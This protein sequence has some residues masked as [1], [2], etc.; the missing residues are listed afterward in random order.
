MGEFLQEG[1]GFPWFVSK[2]ADGVQTTLKI[3]FPEDRPGTVVIVD[4]TMF[5][6]NET[7]VELGAEEYSHHPKVSDPPTVGRAARAA[8]GRRGAG[9]AALALVAVAV[10]AVVVVVVVVV[11]VG[12]NGARARP[13]CSSAT[14]PSSCCPDTC[15]TSPTPRLTSPLMPAEKTAAA[16]AAV[17][18]RWC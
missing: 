3:S 17:A 14:T 4:K 8:V 13:A 7:T 10:V 16:T 18:R 9:Q 11:V 5:G 1:L 6:R 15:V 12:S 2:L